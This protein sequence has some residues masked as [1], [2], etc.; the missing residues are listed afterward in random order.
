MFT[1]FNNDGFRDLFTANGHLFPQVDGYFKDATSYKQRLLLLQNE[2]G[3]KFRDVSEE[4]GLSAFEK[5]VARGAAAADFDNDGRV[6]IAVS[7]LDE[8]PTLIR[9]VAPTATDWLRIRTVGKG[10]NRGGIGA[11]IEVTAGNLKSVDWVHTGGSFQSQNDMRV[12][13]GL[14]LNKKADVKVFWPSGVLD[15]VRDIEVDR[16]IVIEEG[17]GVVDRSHH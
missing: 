14:G 17:S 16:D 6:D 5:H 9:N 3:H 10:S 2:Q 11:R 7:N 13:F 12:H 4:T 8:T 15:A 1:D